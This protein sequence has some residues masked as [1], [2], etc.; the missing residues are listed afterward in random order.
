M[1]LL[2]HTESWMGM[3]APTQASLYARRERQTVERLFNV[4]TTFA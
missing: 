4:D 1:R 2:A 3:Y